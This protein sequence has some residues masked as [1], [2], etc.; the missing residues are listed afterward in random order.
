[1]LVFPYSFCR[2]EEGEE[3]LHQRRQQLPFALATGVGLL[4]DTWMDAFSMSRPPDSDASGNT[5]PTTEEALDPA[6]LLG[7]LCRQDHSVYTCPQKTSPQIFTQMQDMDLEQPQPS[8]EQA[9]LDSRALLSV[10]GQTQASQKRSVTRDLTADSMIESLEQILEDIGNGGIEG[11]EV[12]ET[13]LRDWEN[14]LV[15]TNNERQDVSDDLNQILAN[16]VFSYVEE[17]LRRESGG[18]VQGPDQTGVHPGENNSPIQGQHSVFSSNESPTAHVKSGLREPTVFGN[19]L[20][21]AVC[22]NG[23]K[24]TSEVASHVVTRVQT[25]RLCCNQGHTTPP[26][27]SSSCSH[28]RDSQMIPP[29]SC[30]AGHSQ[31]D[32]TQQSWLLSVKNTNSI[33]SSCNSG[34][35]ATDQRVEKGPSCTQRLHSFTVWQPQ[36]LPQNFHNHTLTQSSH[37]PG[38]SNSIASSHHP[39][40]QP[41]S[42]SCMFE[43][44]GHIANTAAV[45]VV[46][47]GTLLGPTA[48]RGQSYNPQAAPHTPITLSHPDVMMMQ[49]SG[50][51]MAAR[52]DVGNR[53][54]HLNGDNASLGTSQL[55]HP[56]ENGSLQASFHCCN[57]ET[58]VITLPLKTH[59]QLIWDWKCVFASEVPKR[60][61]QLY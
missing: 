4:Y 48:S 49:S 7:S 57:S 40:I 5:K 47:N 9:F 12:E 13:E 53:L 58:Q 2:N 52:T 25:H 39:Q 41:L 36:Q 17:A 21:G 32:A 31:P 6:S 56:S 24:D 46:Q 42:G 55:G 59:F 51:H 1:M 38:S 30:H 43:K 33:H 29:Q 11:L 15:R 60:T 50:S 28:H 20:T 45:P 54:V 34:S 10:P 18:L 3:Q 26:W 23:M 27:P 19:I 8:L 44:R 16:D 14:T 37:T 61:L 35:V 22:S